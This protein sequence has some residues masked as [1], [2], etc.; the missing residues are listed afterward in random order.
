MVTRIYDTYDLVLSWM[1]ILRDEG[2]RSAWLKGREYLRSTQWREKI[3]QEW[4][5]EN[6]PSR[7]EL[8]QQREISKKF[9]YSP[10]IS[11]ITPVYNTSP[12]ILTS[13]I[14]SVLDQTYE[15]WEFCIVDGNS[16]NPEITDILNRFSE[17]D[18]RFR[19]RYLQKNQG[20]SGNSNIAISMATGDFLLFLDHDDTLA[21]FALY[22]VVQALNQNDTLDLLYSDR[23]LL[24]DDGTFRFDPL[25]K[26]DW[27]PEMLLS[28]NY[29]AHL[30][31]VRRSIL[32]TVGVF[33]SEMDGAQDW[34]L[35]FRIVEKT[36]KI[37]HIPKIL[38]HWRSIKTSCATRGQNAK[39]YISH[40]QKKAIQNHLERCNRQGDV[41]LLPQ[42]W[43]RIHWHLISEPLVS[44]IIPTKNLNLLKN[45]LESLFLVTDYKN[46]EI[47]VIDTGLDSAIDPA[48]I[49]KISNLQKLMII[50]YEKPFNYSA[51]NNIGSKHA[52]GEILLFLNDDIRAFS[53]DWLSEMVTWSLQE[54][55]GVVGAK[56]LYPDKT[57]QHAGVVLGLTGFAGHP[58]QASADHTMGLFGSTDW[59][60]NYSAVTGACMM[61]RRGIFEKVGGFNEDFILCG[62]DVT[63]CL[64]VLKMGYR[65]LY[66]PFAILEHCE[67]ASRGSDIPR[68]DFNIS[69]V[70]YSPVIEKGDPFFNPNLSYWNCKPKLKKKDEKLPIDFIRETITYEL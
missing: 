49:N 17:N 48:F 53:P 15:N 68:G 37:C 70:H 60:R 28:V 50:R 61:V 35:F 44:I 1:R 21:P 11:I 10:C 16:D 8:N 47:I 67:S 2:L 45:C 40:A 65:I 14:Q 32:D 56:L 41:T 3:Y 6:E 24:S 36:G 66:N 57:I 58:F 52:K 55:I 23:D 18:P 9:L 7:E 26:P 4:I 59:Y 22:E 30:C 34:D 25:F 46:Y 43:G 69:C 33:D 39:P 54:E 29:L 5:A 64:K 38:Y 20:I 51:A 27:S 12:D 62:S 19:V 42:G 13:T 31:V 63:F